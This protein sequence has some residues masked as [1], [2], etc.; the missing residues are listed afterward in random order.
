MPGKKIEVA[1]GLEENKLLTI[2]GTKTQLLK[3]PVGV[4]FLTPARL[5]VTE[6]ND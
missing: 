6:L 4:K 5:T 3:E 2:P 1:V